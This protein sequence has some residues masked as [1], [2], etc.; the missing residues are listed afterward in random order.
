MTAHVS[1]KCSNQGWQKGAPVFLQDR[2]HLVGC[3]ITKQADVPWLA[4]MS[5]K[6]LARLI[7]FSRSS[8]IIVYIYIHIYLIYIHTYIYICNII[9]DGAINKLTSLDKQELLNVYHPKSYVEPGCKPFFSMFFCFLVAQELQCVVDLKE[10]S[11]I[12]EQNRNDLWYT[13]W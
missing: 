1:L 7:S 12:F 13:L 6:S 8:T 2:S 5:S 4:L 9:A 11:H 10:K 3:L